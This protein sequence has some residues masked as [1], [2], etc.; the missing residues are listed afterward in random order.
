MSDRIYNKLYV[1]RNREEGSD[2]LLL[3]YQ[4][5]GKEIILKKDKET[6][7][8]VPFYTE[9]VKLKDTSL[10]IDGATA[11][12][13]PAASDRILKNRKDYGNVT[14]N[15][16]PSDLADGTWFCSWL[17]RTPEGVVR[18]MDRLYNPG[19]FKYSVAISQLVDGPIYEKNDP[20][21][22]D[23]PSQMILE[24]GV[25][26]RY[27]HAGETNAQNII[28]TF[29]GVSGEHLLLDINQ[30]GDEN[31]NTATF[32]ASAVQPIIESDAP[33]TELYETFESKDRITAPVINFNNSY[34]TEATIRYNKTY[35][36][37]NEFTLSFWAYSPNWKDCQTT[38]L[39]GN[40]S[41]NGGYGLFVQ[42]LSSYPFFVIPETTYGHLLYL[43][44]SA[45]GYKDA[46]LAQEVSM[47]NLIAVDMDNNVV[48]CSN[49]GTKRLHKFDNTGKLLAK[50]TS[51]A[52]QPFTFLSNETPAELFCGPNDTFVV[53]TDKNIYTFDYRL[54]LLNTLVL[55]SSLSAVAGYR[56]DISNNFYELAITDNAYDAKFIETTSWILSTGDGNLYRKIG[57]QAP[58]LF[59]EFSDTAT[60]LAID[61]LEQIWV[62]HGDNRL[63]ILDSTQ[64][65]LSDP[66][67]QT[68]VG[69]N[70]SRQTK[71]INFFCSYDHDAK[72]RTWNCVI[73][74]PD[75]RKLYL[76]DLNGNLTDTVNV[77]NIF[78][79]VI[80]NNEDLNQ[81]P[82]NFTFLS[83]GDFTGYEHRRVFGSLAPYNNNNQLVIRT[84][85]KDKQSLELSFVQFKAIAN[86]G[87]WDKK[88]WQHFVVVLRN[89]KFDVYVN[90]Q[91]IISLDYKST[92]DLS[93]ELQPMFFIGT[94]GGSQSGFNREIEYTSSVF[95]GLIQDIKIYNYALKQTQLE[96]FIRASIPAEDIYWSLPVPNIQYVEKVERMFKNKIPGSKSTFYKIK[97]RGTSIQDTKTRELIEQQIT[98]LVSELQPAYTNFL[99]VQWID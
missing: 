28:T 9:S 50:A 64:D 14:A 29:G 84:S 34:T 56:Y 40:F 12:L 3:G 49:S 75:E 60:K 31:V 16:N 90:G 99:E 5:N 82:E 89:K 11:G 87:N 65:L 59:Y 53:R 10:V 39:A 74:Y 68:T 1:N 27:F 91:L 20:I 70:V 78:D 67:T 55:A 88:S 85:L 96:T 33:V 52:G 79:P 4:H 72:S 54:I 48:A 17:Q 66:I 46:L 86:I 25:M 51:E 76:Y 37:T 81:N 69:L 44:E 7:F 43:N 36:P 13:F 45:T 62:L 94:A 58:E 24:Q 98:Q 6:Y 23:V 80:L 77:N 73:F 38:Q 61:P 8:H 95:N 42:N 30:W 47:A 2:K 21:F 41:S 93:Y 97:L 92:Y 57:N 26:Y 71:D 19:S 22:R 83:R 15:G 35:C 63:T 18:W 32:T